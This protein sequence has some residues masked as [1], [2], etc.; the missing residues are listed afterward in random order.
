MTLW[1]VH[2]LESTFQLTSRY[3]RCSHRPRFCPFCHFWVRNPS[4]AFVVGWKT[5]C[6]LQLLAVFYMIKTPWLLRRFP[7]IIRWAKIPWMYFASPRCGSPLASWWRHICPMSP[8]VKDDGILLC[9]HLSWCYTHTYSLL[10]L[11][12][13][14]PT[15]CPILWT[16][17]LERR[18]FMK[19]CKTW[20][21]I[22]T[23]CW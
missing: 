16:S 14:G 1:L 4:C 15:M 12:S 20:N 19:V 11:A 3:L 9:S 8:T 17:G 6:L 23:V 10:L 2:F 7:F 18:K 13:Q 5:K 22:V 21:C